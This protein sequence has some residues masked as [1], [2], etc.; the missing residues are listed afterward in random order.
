MRCNAPIENA[1][2]FPVPDCACAIISL[3]L[4]IEI[5]DFCCIGLALENP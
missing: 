3:P 2:V 5:M 1:P 4:I